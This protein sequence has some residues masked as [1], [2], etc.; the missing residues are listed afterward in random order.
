MILKIKN[1]I[2]FQNLFPWKSLISSEFHRE[3]DKAQMTHITACY[4]FVMA[5]KCLDESNLWYIIGKFDGGKHSL[6]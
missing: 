3:N 2:T 5:I 1:K 6:L 4:K